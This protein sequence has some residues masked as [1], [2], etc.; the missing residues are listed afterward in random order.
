V[1][2]GNLYQLNAEEEPELPDY[3]K[4][5]ASRAKYGPRGVMD[6]K[7]TDKGDATVDPRFGKVGEQIIKDT[8]PLTKKRM[9]TI[10]DDFAD[11]AVGFIKRQAKA[12]SPFFVWV[13]SHTHLRTHPKPP[14]IGQ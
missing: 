14:S 10:D 8:G 7:A 5:P 11:R 12:D 2:Y 1:F 13:I 4:S 3:P 9:E 6:C